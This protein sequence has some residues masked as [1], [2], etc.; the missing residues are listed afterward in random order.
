MAIKDM[1]E[2]AVVMLQP[3]QRHPAQEHT[4]E[5]VSILQQAVHEF[6]TLAYKVR[7]STVNG[8]ETFMRARNAANALATP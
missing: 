7:N 4:E 6:E 2:I 3:P 1:I 5:R 8:D